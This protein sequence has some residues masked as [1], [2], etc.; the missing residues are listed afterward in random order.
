MRRLWKYIIYFSFSPPPLERKRKTHAG[1]SFHVGEKCDYS[2]GRRWLGQSI[3]DG[4]VPNGKF[5]SFIFIHLFEKWRIYSWPEP[6]LSKL[7]IKIYGKIYLR[8]PLK[9]TA[10]H[11][12]EGN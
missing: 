12:L 7:G 3:K 10:M 11:A 1:C 8:H 2:A 5:L 4:P 6:G 9:V